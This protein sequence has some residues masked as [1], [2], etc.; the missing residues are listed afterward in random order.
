MCNPL[1][2]AWFVPKVRREHGV[3]EGSPK[4]LR[5]F[6]WVCLAATKSTGGSRRDGSLGNC[7]AVSRSSERGSGKKGRL[8]ERKR[9]K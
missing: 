9:G 5:L 2:L 3:N 7:Q 4:L 1:T 8:E 6:V